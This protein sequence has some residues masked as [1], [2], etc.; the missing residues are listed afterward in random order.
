ML[1]LCQQEHCGMRRLLQDT[2]GIQDGTAS[3]AHVLVRLGLEPVAGQ[4][5]VA[6][7]NRALDLIM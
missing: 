1:W 6:C 2:A 7:H 3:P 4:A 5:A